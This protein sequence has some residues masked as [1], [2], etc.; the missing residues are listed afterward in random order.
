MNQAPPHPTEQ[1]ENPR[2]AEQRKEVRRAAQGSVMV[3][4]D[5]PQ[6]FTIHG[7]LVDISSS[8]FRMAHECRTL[9]AGQIV[10]FSH[11]EGAGQAKVVWN[12]ITA[13]RVET[14]FLLVV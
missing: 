12:R 8:G 9:E 7:R 6:P 5:N 14:G 3:R 13:H 1:V 4:F 11:G 2:G 10:E